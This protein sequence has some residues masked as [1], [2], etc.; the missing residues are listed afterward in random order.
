M[1]E[2][3]LLMLQAILYYENFVVVINL[4][5]SFLCGVSRTDLID[6]TIEKTVATM[7]SVIELGRYIRDAKVMPIKVRN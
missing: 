7:Q 1:K 2:I 5:A 4:L 6:S 3:I